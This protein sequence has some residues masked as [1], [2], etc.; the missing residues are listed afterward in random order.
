[1]WL[2]NNLTGGGLTT[3][4][5]SWQTGS[6]T[7]TNPQTGQTTT[8]TTSD[9][10]TYTAFTVDCTPNP[11]STNVPN[12]NCWDKFVR[13]SGNPGGCLDVY[14]GWDNQGNP[15]PGLRFWEI[16]GPGPTGT[17][18]PFC[19]QCAGGSLF[20]FLTPAVTPPNVGLDNV[21]DASIAVDPQRVYTDSKW[22]SRKVMMMGPYEG[23]MTVRNFL[24]GSITQLSRMLRNF[25]NPYFDEC[26]DTDN[27]FIQ[28][29]EIEDLA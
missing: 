22:A 16:T 23:N 8:T 11:G 3:A 20:T 12:H 29:N 6:T 15:L 27:P 25:G 10:E 21:N 5:V 4:S 9:S 14:C 19:S 28:G 1:M 7:T 17:V 18:N 24:S 13:G 2:G 26:S